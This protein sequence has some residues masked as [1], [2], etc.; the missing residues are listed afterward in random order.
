[1]Y[2]KILLIFLVS[3]PIWIILLLGYPLRS[4]S[5]PLPTANT[6]VVVSER[7]NSVDDL[8]KFL[9]CYRTSKTIKGADLIGQIYQEVGDL[10][11]SFNTGF[12]IV[13]CLQLILMAVL[14]LA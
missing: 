3:S 4:K 5:Q 1:M 13:I 11:S 10:H 6:D 2:K 9:D 14:I 7:C 12:Y 8:T